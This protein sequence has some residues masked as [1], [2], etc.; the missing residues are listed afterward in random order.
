MARGEEI[1]T[2]PQ[3]ILM[4]LLYQDVE[5]QLGFLIFPL[6]KETLQKMLL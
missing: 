5:F 4:L 6:A 2:A 1:F 3:I